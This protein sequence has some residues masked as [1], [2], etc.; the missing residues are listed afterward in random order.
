MTLIPVKLTTRVLLALSLF[1]AASLPG[2]AA[3][4]VTEGKQYTKLDNPVKDAPPVVEF[5]SFYCPACSSFYSP[6]QVSK[7]IEAK[8]P[9]GVKVEKYHASFMGEMGKQLT[10]AWSIAKALGVED[11]VEGPLFEA[12]LKHRSVKSED[13]I[14]A[15]FVQAGVDAGE[16]DAAR[17]SFMVK[18][19]TARQ[20]QA[21]EKFGLTGTPA[22]YVNGKYQI[23]N[24]GIKDGSTEGYGKEFAEVVYQLMTTNP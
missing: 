12:V 7:N 4:T 15:V 1:F 24:N 17:N 20:E 5:F 14:K 23:E 22:F 16:F 2:Q 6:Y 8:L 10:E 3:V 18:T 11:K 21:A 13:D 19:L 9:E